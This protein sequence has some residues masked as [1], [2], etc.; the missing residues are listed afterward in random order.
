MLESPTTGAEVRPGS[1]LLL[2]WLYML[3]CLAALSFW[4]V[5]KDSEHPAV[6][7][8][9]QLPCVSLPEAIIQGPVSGTPKAGCSKQPVTTS[10]TAAVQHRFCSPFGKVTELHLE[11]GLGRGSSWGLCIWLA[12]NNS[13]ELQAQPNTWEMLCFNTNALITSERLCKKRGRENCDCKH[14]RIV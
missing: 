7:L 14:H 9:A 5:T 1:G 3:Q 2:P 8:A 12:I 4:R 11:T 13:T 6:G 10:I